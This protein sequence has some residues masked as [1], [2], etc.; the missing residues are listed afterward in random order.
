M[1]VRCDMCSTAVFASQTPHD[2]CRFRLFSHRLIVINI[3]YHHHVATINH[4][5]SKVFRAKCTSAQDGRVC[6]CLH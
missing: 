1:I 4:S 3:Q 5:L 6:I 2:N